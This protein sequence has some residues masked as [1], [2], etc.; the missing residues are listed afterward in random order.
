MIAVVVGLVHLLVAA[1]MAQKYRTVEWNVGPRDAPMDTKG[2][3]ARVERA[4][5]NFMET[6]PLFAAAALAVAVQ[7]KTG[8]ASFWGAAVY[9]V[10]RAV[11]VP[12]YVA[13]IPYIRSLVWAIAT[14]GLVMEIIAAF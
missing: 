10:G 5:R 2:A 8:G 1:Q 6:F 12:L 11:Y 13:G 3:A 4:Y 7:H 9:V 14:I